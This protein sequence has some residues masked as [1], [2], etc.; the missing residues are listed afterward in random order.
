MMRFVGFFLLF[1]GAACGFYM[2]STETTENKISREIA[3]NLFADFLLMDEKS[4]DSV[5]QEKLFSLQ[6]YYLIGLKNLK[7]FDEEVKITPH[8]NIYELES[9]LHLQAV[10]SQT[11]E[12]EDELVE[13]WERINLQKS[14]QNLVLAQKMKSG[15]EE[16]ISQ[17]QFTSIA[18]E[19]LIYKLQV[20]Q[21]INQSKTNKLKWKFNNSLESALKDIQKN[22]EF[23]VYE[24]N[25]EHLAHMLDLKADEERDK[26]KKKISPGADSSG[27]IFGTEFPNKTWSLTFDDGP[28]PTVSS[29]ILEL[30]KKNQLKATFF[31][32]TSNV[33]RNPSVAQKIKDA[34]ME[35]ASHSY[36]HLNLTKVGK[37]TLEKEITQASVE[38]ENFYNLDIQFFRLPYGAGV[39]SPII[40]E[41]IA[42][43][44]MI[45]VFWS[46]DT[47][48]WMPQ[49]S[50]QISDRAIL[51][52]KKAKQDGGIILF[53]DIHARTIMAAEKV[54]NYLKQEERKV[55]TIGQV[56]QQINEGTSTCL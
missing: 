30:L 13:L 32:L 26:E 10:R 22:K 23:L 17:S 53:H 16:F 4:I 42:E 8:E 36:N 50:D 46:V 15:I 54:M 47:L 43:N 14:K 45:H 18:L 31:Q 48:D 6:S 44:K 21:L 27:N 35:I 29:K 51:L 39:H 20:P 2:K 28:H 3:S 38:L 7:R 49:E 25:I 55:C 5:L 34:E 24:K 12:I 52:M 1:F 56:V 33:K 11:E 40:R 41:S 37:I 9:Y 19:N